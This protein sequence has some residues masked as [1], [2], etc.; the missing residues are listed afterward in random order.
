LFWLVRSVTIQ[1]W[2]GQ[3]RERHEMETRRMRRPR[4]QGTGLPVLLV[5]L[6]GV[7]LAVCVLVVPPLLVP[8]PTRQ[9]EGIGPLDRAQ[10]EHERIGLQNQARGTLLQAFTGVFLLVTA[11]LTWRQIQVNRQGHITDRFTNAVQQL[12]EDGK[13]DVRLGGIYALERIASESPSEHAA[14]VEILVAY[15]RGH[16]AA[17]TLDAEPVGAAL[18]VRAA[19]V[20]AAMTVLG[21]RTVMSG[22]P[23]ALQLDYLDLRGALLTGA[24]LGLANL[25]GSD[26]AGSG[27]QAA[28]LRGSDLARAR[29]VEADLGAASLVGARLQEADLSRAGLAG[30]DLET[31]DLRRANLR[32]ADLSGSRLTRADLRRAN[33][34]EANLERAELEGALLG[35]ANLWQAKLLGANLRGADLSRGML[36]EVDLDHATADRHTVWP[37]GFDW[38]S[39]GVTVVER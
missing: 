38:R 21:R 36:V 39:A 15:V 17:A 27:L 7:L 1:R 9:I 8:A 28:D 6:T 33:L 18:R 23:P 26:L 16:A 10:L 4:W 5:T 30:A 22:D 34:G 2:A 3:S 37:S 25:S 12:G 31:A 14:I 13:L 35:E 24:D 11:F 19:D 32:G 29:L 20:Q